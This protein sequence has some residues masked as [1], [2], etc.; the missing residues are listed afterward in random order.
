MSVLLLCAYW[1]FPLRLH[2]IFRIALPCSELPGSLS[3][4]NLFCLL[5]QESVYKIKIKVV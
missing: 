1:V 5:V 3:S 2:Q 4:G